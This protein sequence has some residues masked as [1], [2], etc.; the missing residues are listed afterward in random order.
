MTDNQAKLAAFLVLAWPFT[1]MA[2]EAGILPSG[3]TVQGQLLKDRQ[4]RWV[5]AS[6]DRKYS[7]GQLHRVRLG[8]TGEAICRAGVVYRFRLR[9]DQVL[10]G[11]LLGLSADKVRIRL[12]CTKGERELAR[13]DLRAIEQ[14][15]GLAFLFHDDFEDGLAAWKLVGKPGLSEGQATSGKK[16]LLLD[17]AGQAASF[18]LPQPVEAGKLGLNFFDPGLEAKGIW[19][20]EAEFRG[21]A[22]PRIVKISFGDAPLH[23]VALP[24][25]PAGQVLPRKPGWHRLVLDFSTDSLRASVD[26]QVLLSARDWGSGPL[27]RVTLRCL[28]ARG[29]AKIRGQAWFDDVSIA[30]AVASSRAVPPA[31]PAQDEIV[32]LASDQLPGKVLKAD[33]R[34]IDF[35]TLAGKKVIPWSQVRGI[36]LHQ[37]ASPERTSAGQHVR[38]WLRSGVGPELDQLV[39][40]LLTL[41]GKGLVIRH[42]CL[43]ELAIERGWVHELQGLVDGTRQELSNGVH[44][45][46]K[47]SLPGSLAPAPHGLA[48]KRTFVLDTLPEQA[49]LVLQVARIEGADDDTEIAKSLARGGKRTEVVVNGKVVDYLN[50]HLRRTPRRP[51]PVFVE[52][53]RQALRKGKNELVLRQTIDRSTGQS[54]DCLILDLAVEIPRPN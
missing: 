48:W 28:P 22:G 4:G 34:N 17:T 14:L 40:T 27:V 51:V 37:A 11:E 15:P 13:A 2:G 9:D 20:V 3:K 19:L 30:R 42:P 23:G 49:R 29:Q 44:H 32:T 47:T 33:R 35:Q 46:G 24:G 45:L 38:L 18:E 50:R 1:A 43:G 12:A 8:G 7:L 31:D 53:P 39:G 41:D 16:S 26:D 21:K 36:R 10:T 25:A 54:G 6:K 5:F 52:L